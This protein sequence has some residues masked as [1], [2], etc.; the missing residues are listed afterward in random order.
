MKHLNRVICLTLAD[1]RTRAVRKVLESSS[2]DDYLMICDIICK[3]PISRT[4]PSER[5]IIEIADRQGHFK[6]RRMIW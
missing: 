4:V 3:E 1:K 5:E 2:Y 6:I